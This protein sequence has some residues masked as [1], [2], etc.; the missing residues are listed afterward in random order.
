MQRSALMRAADRFRAELRA[1]ESQ[2]AGRMLD[3]Y[4]AAHER[5]AVELERLTAEIAA[6]ERN[7]TPVG[8]SWLFQRARLASLEQQVRHEITRFARI[9]GAETRRSQEN[10]VVL[11][12]RHSL[13]GVRTAVAD[14][15]AVSVTWTRA[16]LGAARELVGLA[17][18]GSPLADLLDELGPAAAKGVR[19]ALVSGVVLGHNPRKIARRV[20]QVLDGNAARALTISR[21]ETLRAYREATRQN[22]LANQGVVKG[23]IWTSAL[24]R[25]TCPSCWAMH[26]SEHSLDE[27][28]D[29]HPSCRCSMM[30]ATLSFKE[31]GLSSAIPE[32]SAASAIGSGADEFEAI[33]QAARAEILGPAKAKLYERGRIDLPDLVV[34]TR[35]A[36]WGTMR[37][38]ASV[39]E[40]LA[41][42]GRKRRR[43]AA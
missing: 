40:A 12:Q 4:R 37:R 22:Y 17:S 8:P 5:I 33:G 29:G 15:P 32:T 20:S 6:A 11:A 34:R 39:K 25:R 36:R 24:D 38:E 1:N 9:A 31:L 42:A 27:Q 21:T 43:A 10:V 30:P 13:E 3:A 23:W 16:P 14:Q 41:N 2:A 28:L 26:G 35:N 18:D 7:G 19:Q